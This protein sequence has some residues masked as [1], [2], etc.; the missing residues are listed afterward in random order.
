MARSLSGQR[1]A[2]HRPFQLNVF[3]DLLLVNLGFVTAASFAL[4]AIPLLLG[5]RRWVVIIST[6]VVFLTAAYLIFNQ[7][8]DKALPPD[9][10]TG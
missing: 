7:F 3:F 2:K 9:W 8:V 1:R 5:E 4:I 10:F 6:A